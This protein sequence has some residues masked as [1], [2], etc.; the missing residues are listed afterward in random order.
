MAEKIKTYA[1][2]TVLLFG[3]GLLFYLFFRYAFGV[4]APFLFGYLMAVVSGRPAAFLHKRYRLPEGVCRLVLS[5][6]FAGAL[7][8]LL[9]FSGR[10]L[11]RELGGFIDSLGKETPEAVETFLARLPFLDKLLEEGKALDRVSDALLSFLP[12]A[13]SSLVSFLPALLFSVG[14]GAIASVY[15]CLDLERVHAAFKRLV[16]PSLMPKLQK[17]KRHLLSAL[18]SLLRSSGILMAIAFVMMF[19]GFLLLDIPY[20]FLFSAVF[21]LFDLLPVVGVGAFL[22]P[23]GV[24]KLILGET[25][26]GIGVLLLFALITV[27]RQFAEPRLLGARQGVHPLVTLFA[28]YAGARLFGTVGLLFFPVL[29]LL[30]HG[31]LFSENADEKEKDGRESV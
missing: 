23:L 12:T 6:L 29:T 22:L 14:V 16:P 7:G 25:Y 24:G 18:G 21:A 3:G 10:V 9:F 2:F 20:A 28:L 11:V 15:F 31:L 30:L 4:L 8:L 26:A 19:V 17:G 5:L 13:L 1:A 27:V